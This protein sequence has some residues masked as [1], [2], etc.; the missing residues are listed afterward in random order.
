VL[1][2][3]FC[4]SLK[5]NLFGDVGVTAL[6]GALTG[7]MSFARLEYVQALLPP[8]SVIRFTVVVCRDYSHVNELFT[9]TLFF[10]AF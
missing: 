5:T 9:H 10:L 4:G 8:L 2:R 1:F 7:M 6:A 3:L